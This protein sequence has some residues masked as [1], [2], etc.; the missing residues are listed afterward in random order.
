MIL[1]WWYSFHICKHTLTVAVLFAQCWSQNYFYET[2]Q[3]L[4]YPL[5]KDE[6]HAIKDQSNYIDLIISKLQYPQSKEI[7]KELASSIYLVDNSFTNNI[8]SSYLLLKE[9]KILQ[10]ALLDYIEELKTKTGADILKRKKKSSQEQNERD[11]KSITINSEKVL[12]NTSK[13]QEL[14]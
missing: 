2:F 14:N 4:Y 11:E 12:I 9:K 3:E 6:A 5:V 8:T 10:A 13:V 1:P 7:G